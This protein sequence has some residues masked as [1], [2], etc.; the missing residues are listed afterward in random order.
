MC[1]LNTRV[2]GAAF[3]ESRNIWNVKTDDGKTTS[4]QFLILCT[5]FAAKPYIPDIAGLDSYKGACHHT[6]LWPQEGLD[7]T[8]KRVA[9]IGTGASGIQVIQEASKTAAQLT[10]FQ[11]TPN[12]TL[13]MRQRQISKDENAQLKQSF[14]ETFASRADGFAGF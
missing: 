6:G 13:P 3:D 11:R 8:G 9:V 1:L 10:V 14:P 12:L 5:G 2:T 7:F 4:A